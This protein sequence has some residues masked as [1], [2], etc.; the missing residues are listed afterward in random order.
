MLA[1]FTRDPDVKA[2]IR[3]PHD[4]ARDLA[5]KA[6]EVSRYYKLPAVNPGHVALVGFG[7]AAFKSGER[8]VT[9][10]RA[11]QARKGKLETTDADPG[12]TLRGTMPEGTAWM[13]PLN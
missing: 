7:I 9:A 10:I 2:A 4:E 3:M 1:A 5:R 13:P 8:R 11:I 6:A 12:P